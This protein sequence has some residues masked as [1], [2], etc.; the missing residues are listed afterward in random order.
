M[1]RERVKEGGNAHGS[2][3]ERKILGN[4]EWELSVDYQWELSLRIIT[5]NLVYQSRRKVEIY[6]DTGVSKNTLNCDCW[7]SNKT[8]IYVSFKHQTESGLVRLQSRDSFLCQ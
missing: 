8:K 7:H 6:R 4:Y 1:G 2:P 3:F 5:E